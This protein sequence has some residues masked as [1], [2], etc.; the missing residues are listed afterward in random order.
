MQLVDRMVDGQWKG[1]WVG[2]G[3]A[4]GQDCGQAADSA[5]SPSG[6]HRQELGRDCRDA[7]KNLAPGAMAV[8]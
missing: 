8:T 1:W 7:D 2:S 4:S 5:S 6:R 3:Q